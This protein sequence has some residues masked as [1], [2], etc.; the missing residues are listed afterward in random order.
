MREPAVLL[1]GCPAVV[2]GGTRGIGLAI[3]QALHAAGADLLIAGRSA[4]R[5]RTAAEQL[6]ADFCVAD[7]TTETGIADLHNRAVA[8]WG[9]GPDLLVNA[10]GAFALAPV[11]ETSVESFDQQ[12]AAN[13]RAPFLLIRTFLPGMRERGRGHIV[14]IGSI[15]GRRAFANNGAYSASKFGVLGLHAVLAEELRGTGVRA[16]LIEP[17]ATDTP[18]WDDIDRASNP[19]LPHREN[20]M[21]PD[22]VAAA[23]IFAAT[24]SP[25][26]AVPNLIV[27]RS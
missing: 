9:R 18:L 17:A 10:V 25:S 13:L 27:E 16:T 1:N 7:L 21:N 24:Q 19:G 4:D 15:A 12:V 26:V 8:R 2:A 22:A 23:V 11:H 14:T 5:A 20:M 3:A 6:A